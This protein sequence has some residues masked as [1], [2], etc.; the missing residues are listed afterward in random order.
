MS[1]KL[2]KQILEQLRALSV[3]GPPERIF[4]VEDDFRFWR[5]LPIE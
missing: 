3:L 2:K 5:L 1:K 4:E